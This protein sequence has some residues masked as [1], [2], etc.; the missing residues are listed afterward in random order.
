VIFRHLPGRVSLS[1]S[2]VLRSHRRF[3]GAG[4]VTYVL[5][6]VPQLVIPLLLIN[7]L[8]PARGA[9]FFI[10]VQIVT[11]QN[12]I[13]LA[14]GN[15]MYAESE[16]SPRTRRDV[17]RRGGVTMAILCV[18][19]MVVMLVLAPYFLAVFGSHYAD[20][21]TTT[22]RVLSACTLLFAFNYWSAMRLRIAQ[23]LRAMIFVQLACTVTVL[24]LAFVAAPHGT[25]WVAAA[26][27]AGQLVG[28]V[29]GYVVSVTVAPV[30]DA[31]DPDGELQRAGRL[32]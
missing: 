4:Y 12:S 18:V 20:Q 29:L 16:R 22:L 1:P 14:V 25:V 15:S 31:V 13:I 7:A 9:V 28:G 8:G 19:S 3:A 32:S 17:V 21:G 5:N 10:S 27:G 23:H 26:W 2:S 6:V 11:L 30:T 24:V